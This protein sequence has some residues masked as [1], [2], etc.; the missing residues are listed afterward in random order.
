MTDIVIPSAGI[1][2]EEAMVV[3]WHKAPGDTVAADEPVVEIET[4][5][6]TMDV[7]SP[8]AGR[9]GPHL[10]EPGDVVAVGAA[11]VRVLTEEAVPEP[12][13]APEPDELASSTG[14]STPSSDEPEPEPC[15][16]RRRERRSR[17]RA[18]CAQPAERAGSSGSGRTTRRRPLRPGDAF[19]A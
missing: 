17:P 3:K 1:A 5:K 6:A 12:A 13:R 8:V 14:A 18:S 2:M 4:D 19:A 7:V 10:A 15:L 11:I 9:L 16:D